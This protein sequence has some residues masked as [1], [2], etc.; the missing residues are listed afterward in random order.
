MGISYLGIVSIHK[1]KQQRDFA[2]YAL[3][4]A[5]FD[6]ANNHGLSLVAVVGAHLTTGCTTLNNSLVLF[7]PSWRLPTKRITSV[8]PLL[9]RKGNIY[10]HFVRWN[11]NK[12]IRDAKSK[13]EKACGSNENTRHIR[14]RVIRA[15][16]FN[17]LLFDKYYM[18]HWIVFQRK[19]ENDLRK[20]LGG[21]SARRAVIV[22]PSCE[23]AAGI[24]QVPNGSLAWRYSKR[25]FFWENTQK[26]FTNTNQSCIITKQ[27]G[28][29]SVGRALEWHS[30]GRRF[31]P[32]HLHHYQPNSNHFRVR[33]FI[34]PTKYTFLSYFIVSKKIR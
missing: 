13:N 4:L 15:E 12:E 32:D 27:W 25:K 9:P 6:S 20:Q 19:I 3:F 18:P 22:P 11:W 10:N 2:A 21:T 33:F 24:W 30:R 17:N 28:C 1:R 5:P 34:C 31:D 8:N 23:A 29:S 26:Q 16:W 14:W 7:A